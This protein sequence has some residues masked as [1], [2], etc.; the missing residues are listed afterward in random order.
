MPRI[1]R[2][3]LKNIN[4]KVDPLNHQEVTVTTIVYI[5][6]LSGYWQNSLEILKIFF[7]SLYQNTNQPFD[8]MVLDNGSCEEVQAYLL[9]LKGK[10]KIQILTF[11]TQNLRKLG[12]L[13]FLLSTAP[14]EFIA[15]ADSDVLFLPG[16]LEGSL[17]IL[18][19]F[20]EAGKVTSLPI[21][22]GDS[23]LLPT[24]KIAMNDP[25]ITIKTGEL[26]PDTFIDAHR[27]SLG[28]TKESYLLRMKNRKDV[29]LSRYGVDALL[30]GS[31]FQFTISRKAVD[32]VLPLIIEDPEEY[33]DPIYSPILEKKLSNAGFWQLCTPGYFVHHI[34][35][36]IPDLQKELPWVKPGYINPIDPG[37]GRKQKRNRSV[38]DKILRIGFVRR[39]LKRIYLS[40]YKLLYERKN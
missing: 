23:T 28:Q 12:A 26:I 16:W 34:G 21:V 27:L 11:S 18:S 1:G 31:D 10:G 19:T 6:T 4:A 2:H 24:Y 7:D 14:G 20:P 3:P 30:S 40:S 38:T 17:R 9:E 29:V 15:Y 39:I 22:G 37:G 5:P 36:Q 8:L 13:N 32:S 33:Y 35:N 25:T